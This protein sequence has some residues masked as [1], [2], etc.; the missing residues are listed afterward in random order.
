MKKYLCILFL[1]ALVFL[2]VNSVYANG[3]PVSCPA[4][5]EPG[6]LVPCGRTC[7]DPSTPENECKVCALCD[8]FVMFERI[9]DYIL[10]RAAPGIA[11]LMIAIGGFMYMF[12]YL[13]PAGGGPQLIS[14]AKS[15]FSAVGFGL[16]ILYGAWLIVDLFLWAIGVAEWT[17]LSDGGWSVICE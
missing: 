9:F 14:R 4:C 16:L 5:P 3:V 11:I 15:L 2:F 12:A 17:G 10:F 6:G 8:F 13:N 7:D 1:A